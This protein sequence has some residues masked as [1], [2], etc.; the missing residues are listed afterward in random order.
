MVS[1][2]SAMTLSNH[3]RELR[4][5]LV[6]SALA[7]LVGTI[8]VW[9]QFASIF[10]V[11]RKP[12]DQI[13]SDQ[14]VLALTGVTSGFS[15]QLR[16]SLSSAIVLTSPIWLYQIWRFIAPGLH[17][18][19][20]KWAYIFA[21]IATPL[22][23]AGVALA[24][25]VMPRMLRVLFEFTPAEVS[26]VTSVDAY[27]S[28]FL[29]LTIFFGI[30]FLLP[31]ILVFLNFVGILTGAKIA[32]SWR[33]LILSS[34]VFGAVATPNGDPVGMTFVAMPMILLSGIALTVALIN[35]RRRARKLRKSG[36][37]QWS[38][39]TQSDL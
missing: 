4:N 26:N 37:D 32:H 35:D 21:G 18:S 14:A 33:W 38:D 10:A 39:L 9:Q 34:F 19:E 27:L 29:Q 5:R 3:L 1:A 31:L 13:A 28:F 36:T 7:I 11:I 6:K 12:F 8:S 17:G 30:G 16:V 2:S 25:Y 23:L 15:L 24:Y 22:F 20:K